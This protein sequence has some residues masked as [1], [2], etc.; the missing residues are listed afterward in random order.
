MKTLEQLNEAEKLSIKRRKHKGN[1]IQE[2]ADIIGTT[3]YVVKK[4]LNANTL[5]NNTN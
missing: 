2:I 1:S 5:K 3:Q 4:V